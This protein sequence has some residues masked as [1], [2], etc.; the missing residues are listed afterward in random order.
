MA[1]NRFFTIYVNSKP[2]GHARTENRQCRALSHC[3]L[4]VA[5]GSG[6]WDRFGVDINGQKSIFCHL[7]QFQTTWTCQDRKSAVQGPVPSP[8][9]CT[10]QFWHME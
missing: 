2:H 10:I 1:E 4:L 3:R 7:C 5:F 8:F 9:T 6:T